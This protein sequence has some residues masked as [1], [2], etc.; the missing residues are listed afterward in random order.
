MLRSEIQ[1]QRLHKPMWKKKEKT[2]YG[3]LEMNFG[4]VIIIVWRARPTLP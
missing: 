3:K 4:V 1:Q 2:D